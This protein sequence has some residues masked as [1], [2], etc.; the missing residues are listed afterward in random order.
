LQEC[1]E[2]ELKFNGYKPVAPSAAHLR[3]LFVI[4]SKKSFY[5]RKKIPEK[6]LSVIIL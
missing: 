3:L 5:F 1:V 6:T 4:F 2:G